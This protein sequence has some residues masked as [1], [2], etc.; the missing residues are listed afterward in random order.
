MLLFWDFRRRQS[1]C[2]CKKV[3]KYVCSLFVLFFPKSFI[4]TNILLYACLLTSKNIEIVLQFP[5]NWE[6]EKDV[7]AFQL[8]LYW[9]NN[10]WRRE[11]DRDMHQNRRILAIIQDCRSREGGGGHWPSQILADQLTLSQPRGGGR[12]CPPNYYIPPLQIF[13]PSYGSE[14]EHGVADIS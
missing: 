4:S 12:L 11:P 14:L 13:R 8:K 1:S 2:N 9:R 6:F 5:H 10:N 3:I 7:S